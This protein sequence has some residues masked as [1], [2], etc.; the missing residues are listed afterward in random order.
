MH[1]FKTI[2][3]FLYFNI[4]SV[5]HLVILVHYTDSKAS[6]FFEWCQTLTLCCHTYFSGLTE[7]E[8]KIWQDMMR[9][10]GALKSD[11]I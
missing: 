8:K 7:F 6:C 4:A 9:G 11:M 5:L 1:K 3:M 2:Q 10:G